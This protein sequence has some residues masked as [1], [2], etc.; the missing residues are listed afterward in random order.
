MRTSSSSRSTR[1][2]TAFRT[3]SRIFRT[4]RFPSVLGIVDEPARGNGHGITGQS[5]VPGSYLVENVTTA[6]S[7]TVTSNA[8]A[9]HSI[10]DVLTSGLSRD[11]R[12]IRCRSPHRMRRLVRPTES[13]RSDRSRSTASRCNTTCNR[14][15]W[16][17]SLRTFKRRFKPSIR[18]SR[19]RWSAA[20]CSSHRR[21]PRFRSAAARTAA[22]C[23]T[24]CSSATRSS[25]TRSTSGSIIGTVDVGGINSSASFNTTT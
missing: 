3:R 9:G 13:A 17:R 11:C 14:S 23:S 21:P 5:A 20:K 22:T 4:P 25:T 7:S 18:R 2:S 15:R 6:T 19:R 10:T 12:R 16:T 24:S 1:C 8:A